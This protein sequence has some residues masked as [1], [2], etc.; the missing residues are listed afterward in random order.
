[1]ASDRAKRE[2]ASFTRLGETESV[3]Y[4]PA[5]QGATPRTIDAL[6]DRQIPSDVPGSHQGSGV[7]HLA[8][9]NDTVLGITATEADRGNDTISV[10]IHAGGAA[11]ARTLGRIVSQDVDFVTF[12]VR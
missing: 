1:M 6:V 5:A 12:E 3:V 7:T 10:A 11:V 2:M 9:L 4:T 8:V